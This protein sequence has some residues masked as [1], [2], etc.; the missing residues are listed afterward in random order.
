[1][2]SSYVLNTTL[3]KRVH[4]IAVGVVFFLQGLCFASWGARIPTIQ[5][6]LGLSEAALGLVLFALPAGQMLS[7]PFSGWIIARTGS[8]K[9]V[10]VAVLLYA[11]VLV[12][13]GMAAT[14]MQLVAGLFLF[15]IAGNL[16]NIGINTQAVGVEALYQRSIMASFHGLWSLAAFT[17]AAVGTLM[18]GENVLPQ[19]HFTLIAVVSAITAVAAFRF[20]LP[21]DIDADKK[22]PVFVMP[23]KSL[24]NLGLIAF[25]SLICEGAMFDWSGVYFKKVVLA[26]NAW[27]GLGYTA[28]MCTMASGRFVA[29]WF[30]SRFGMK[31]ILQGSGILTASGLLLAV[32]F[33]NIITATVG[34]L[35]VGAGVSSVVPL[36]YS[37]AGKTKVM[38]AGAALAAVSTIGFLGFLLGPPLI[39]LVAGATS[40]RVS[41]C[42]IAF[43]GL[44]VTLVASKSKS[45]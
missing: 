44:C 29:D 21:E 19:Q 34:F 16:V 32:A 23:D 30:T 15:G 27:V 10:T 14:R 2:S 31:T 42:I 45:L 35:L 6:K 43:M 26:E 5:Q 20:I 22:Q 25:C 11:L 3:P 24:L 12:T 1:M 13:L 18:I 4:R 33:P 38:S 7:L 40:L 36:V 8:R 17:G 28:F 37:A 41:Y 39:G 9:V